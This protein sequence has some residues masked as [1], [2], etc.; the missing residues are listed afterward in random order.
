MLKGM[1]PRVGKKTMGSTN[2]Y[3]HVLNGYQLVVVGE[4]PAQ[5]VEQ[6][7]QQVTFKK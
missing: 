4:V 1:Q 7:A 2:V 6:I 3:A 5:T